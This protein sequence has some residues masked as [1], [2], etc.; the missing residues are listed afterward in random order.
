MSI[1]THNFPVP[2]RFYSRLALA[3]QQST[4][5]MLENMHVPVNAMSGMSSNL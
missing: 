3:Q 2:D 4:A 5:D 1:L